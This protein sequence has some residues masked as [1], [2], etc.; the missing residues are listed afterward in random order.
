MTQPSQ[1]DE[2][3]GGPPVTEVALRP[4]VHAALV[5]DD[6][7]LL[8]VAAD[9]YLCVRGGEAGAIRLAAGA[10]CLQLADSDLAGELVAAGLADPGPGPMT[11]PH[12]AWPP[13]PTRSAV[14]DS[15]GAPR[16][17]DVP[18]ALAAMACVFRDYR[19]HAL[20][21]LIGTSARRPTRRA[22]DGQ[23]PTAI[24]D[25]FHRWIPF[26]PVSGKCLLR[27]FILRRLLQRAGHEPAWVFGVQTW[28]FAAHCWL[29]IGDVVLDDHPDRVAA[30]TP[31]MVV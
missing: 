14:R 24:I 27:A 1:P 21:H 18:E 23:D 29:Q 28:P 5:G 4:S 12:P 3:S 10:R 16:W 13:P 22:R 2:I 25:R 6:L 26:A 31:I 17:S 9:A 20:S 11:G 15:Y 7:V 8:D 19:G 30:Y